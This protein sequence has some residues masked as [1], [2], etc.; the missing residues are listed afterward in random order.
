M[1]KLLSMNQALDEYHTH[2]NAVEISKLFEMY[3]SIGF[4][5]PAK[6]TLLAPYIDQIQENWEK[7]YQNE[8]ELLWIFT[9]NQDVT[10]DFAS[11]CAWRYLT[12]T[13]QAQHLV[14]TGNPFL[15][16]KIMLCAQIKAHLENE[17][18]PVLASQNWFRPNNRYAYRV[19]ASMV[20]RLGTQKASL[21]LFQYLHLKF[22]NIKENNSNKYQIDAINGVD[23]KLIDFVKKE[24]GEVFVRGEELD[25]EDVKLERLNHLFQDSQLSRSRRILKIQDT[26]HNKI[27]AC[28]L[29][30]RAPLGINF[31]FL[32]N[33]AYYILDQNLSKEERFKLLKI[34]NSTVKTYYEDI[35]IQAIPIVTDEKTAEALQEQ[36]ATL[37]K[38]YLQSIWLREGFM[39]WF[40]HI[41]S[42]LQRIKHREAKHK[43]SQV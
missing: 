33:R 25:I 3:E 17:K 32:E 1:N 40:E 27:I 6:K 39:E 30:N 12:H 37:F 21:I 36:K 19:F 8:E 24:L 29:I 4:I 26:D 16:L 7:L 28:V 20:K 22:E 42:F 18:N 14:S 41:M 9:N 11:V 35:A 31:S 2:L 34:I 23:F 15:S 5:Y 43:L 38:A 13:M 10:E